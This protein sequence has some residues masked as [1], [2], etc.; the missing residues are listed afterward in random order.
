MTPTVIAIDGPAASGK[1][2]VSR[3]VADRLGLNYINSGSMYRAMTWHI[4]YSQIDPTNPR[5]V[6]DAALAVP[7]RVGFESR[8]SFFEVDGFCPIEQLR[9]PAVN[10]AVSPVS[11][12]PE[13]RTRVVDGIRE[14]SSAGPAVIEGRDIGSVVFPETPYKIYLDASPEVRAR[15][16]AAEGEQDEIAARDRIDSSRHTAPLRIAADARVID[17]SI[18]DLDGVIRAVVTLLAQMDCPEA[19]GNAFELRQ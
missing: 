19:R 10:R 16:R 4:L 15:R 1:S 12:V 5:L 11:A 7:I 14:L 6:A 2:S 17:T 8:R 3:G 18:L 13:V 9:D